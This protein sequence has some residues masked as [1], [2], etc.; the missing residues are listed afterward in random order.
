MN[1]LPQYENGAE[2]VWA[3]RYSINDGTYNSNLNWGMGLTTPQ[4]LGCCDF[5]KPSQNLVNAFK[6]DSQGKPLFSTYD[7]ENYEVATDNVDPRLFIRWV[8]RAFLIS[9]TKVTSSRR[10][11]TGAAARDFMDIMFLSQRECRSRL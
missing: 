11:M 7:N 8:C 10:M 2:S 3:I 6:T 1:F 4:I 5:H 9:T